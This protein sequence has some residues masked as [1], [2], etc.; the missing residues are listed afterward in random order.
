M[1]DEDLPLLPVVQN[2]V[3]IGVLKREKVLYLL[4]IKLFL[5]AVKNV[6]VLTNN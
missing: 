5:V 4:S 1:I 6:I 3:V 2:G